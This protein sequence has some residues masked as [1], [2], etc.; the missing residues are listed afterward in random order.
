MSLRAVGPSWKV[1]GTLG[2]W[3]MGVAGSG[4]E[5][6]PGE[7]GQVRIGMEKHSGLLV[8][9]CALTPRRWPGRQAQAFPLAVCMELDLTSPEFPECEGQESVL[10]G[11]RVSAGEEESSKGKASR[12]QKGA[13]GVPGRAQHPGPHGLQ[14]GLGA[15]MLRPG[16]WG[17]CPEAGVRVVTGGPVVG[18]LGVP[19]P[20]SGPLCLCSEDAGGGG[21]DL[22]VSGSVF[23]AV[24]CSAC[25]PARTLPQAQDPQP[26]PPVTTSAAAGVNQRPV[27][28]TPA[29]RRPLG[30]SLP[31]HPPPWSLIR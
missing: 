8:W 11:H 26:V 5:R 10:L 23:R 31:C 18:L 1:E 2:T 4:R 16:M 13:D 29:S 20:S 3:A 7:E 17:R 22:S 19:C 30:F 9:S 27:Q 25:I 24:W 14:G 15:W 6:A 12:G 28:A 21:K